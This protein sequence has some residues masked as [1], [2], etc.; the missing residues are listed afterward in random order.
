MITKENYKLAE[1]NGTIDCLYGDVVNGYVRSR[2]SVSEEISVIRQRE[3]KPAEF[4]EYYT[5]VEQ[6]KAR[7]KA[8]FAE[9]KGG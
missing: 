5:F 3:E 4:A 8:E 7:A 6:C 2:Y 1:L 9:L